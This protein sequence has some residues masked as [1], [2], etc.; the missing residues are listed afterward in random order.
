MTYDGSPVVMLDFKL[1]IAC[2]YAVG[3]CGDCR[4]IPTIRRWFAENNCDHELASSHHW[5]DDYDLL[6]MDVDGKL[7]TIFADTLIEL[8][9]EFFSVGSGRMA[10]MGAMAVGAS[11]EEAIHVASIYDVNTGLPVQTLT[12]ETLRAS[13]KPAKIRK[14]RSWVK[15]QK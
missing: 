8:P 9:M 6:A 3:F 15:G 2:G 5:N 7:Y 11:A 1:F 4:L 10:A 14:K 13:I 12:L